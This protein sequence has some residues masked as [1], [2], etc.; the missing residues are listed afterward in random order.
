METRL[1]YIPEHTDLNSVTLRHKQVL[2]ELLSL[3]SRVDFR[4]LAELPAKETPKKKHYIIC[5]IEQV[6]QIARDNNFGL[7][8]KYD[9]FYLYNGAYWQLLDDQQLTDFLGK[10][11]EKMGVEKFDARHYQFR[12]ELLKQFIVSAHLQRPEIGEGITIINLLNGTLEIGVKTVL[13]P[14]DD[15]DFITYQFTIRLR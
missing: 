2:P 8:R 1:A 3:I 13:R 12:D 6:L 10:A 14:F 9:F 15:T 7:A 4:E 5:V 11:A